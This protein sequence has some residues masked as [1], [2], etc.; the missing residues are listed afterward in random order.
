MK[1]SSS[2][3]MILM[4]Y[5]AVAT[6]F[7]YN[8]Y[9]ADQ[10]NPTRTLVL[11]EKNEMEKTHSKFIQQFRDKGHEVT[12]ISMDTPASGSTTSTGSNNFPLLREF[13]VPLYENLAILAPTFE[14][15][16]T[17]GEHSI[18]SILRFIDDGGNLFLATGNTASPWVCSFLFFSLIV[19][20]TK[21]LIDMMHDMCICI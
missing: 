19:L 21:Y 4:A 18:I 1:L 9:A 15:T 17:K 10:A 2:W 12:V 3:I 14:L 20:S 6:N 8:A 5:I 7:M 13:G 11:L 16:S